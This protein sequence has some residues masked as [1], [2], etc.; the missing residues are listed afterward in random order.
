MID[1][2]VIQITNG[3][4]TFKVLMAQEYYFKLIARLEKAEGEIN[5]TNYDPDIV[6]NNFE[7]KL[8]R[9]KTTSQ[10]ML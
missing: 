7:G 8:T 9:L 2:D 1:G 4:D 5:R 3:G 10:K 6:M